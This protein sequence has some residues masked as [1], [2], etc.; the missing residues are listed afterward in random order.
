VEVLTL[1]N[2]SPRTR[3]RVTGLSVDPFEEFL[4]SW[5]TL[6]AESREAGTTIL[7]EGER[8]RASL[9]HLGI[10]GPIGLVHQGRSLPRTAQELAHRS[11]RV[12]ILTDW[13]LEGGHLAQR[14]RLLLEAGSVAVELNLRRRLARAVRGEVVHVEGLARWARRHAERLGASLDHFLSTGP[15]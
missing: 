4:E 10:T 11:N 7:V 1:S 6:Q 3:S 13:D 14:L 12:I 2:S 8:D 5:R 15:A 9:R